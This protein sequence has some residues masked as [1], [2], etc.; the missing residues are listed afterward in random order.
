MLKI[1]DLRDTFRDMVSQHVYSHSPE[2]VKLL[3]IELN[4]IMRKLELLDLDLLS[5]KLRRILPGGR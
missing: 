5:N 3:P 2:R 1:I 4:G